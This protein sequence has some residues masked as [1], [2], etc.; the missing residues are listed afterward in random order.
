MFPIQIIKELCT[1]N[2]THKRSDNAQTEKKESPQD[3]DI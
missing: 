3:P 1:E 2:Y